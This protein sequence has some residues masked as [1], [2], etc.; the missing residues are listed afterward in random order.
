MKSTIII[1]LVCKFM[2]GAAQA[3]PVSPPG[4]PLD[5]VER[6]PLSHDY[7]LIFETSEYQRNIRLTGPDI[8]TVIKSKSIKTTAPYLGWLHL[9]QDEYFILYSGL[10]PQVQAEVYEKKSGK[11][12]LKGRLIEMD[13]IN[14]LLFFVHWE[15]DSKLGIFD[16][17]S[18][19]VKYHTPL[20]TSCNWWWECIL[21]KEVSANEVKLEFAQKDNQ[22]EQI[23]FSR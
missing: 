5:D 7:A 18:S 20:A 3:I 10:E 11:A 23:S 13:T 6:V 19:T 8:S 1:I 9:D 2:S 4:L 15:K 16:L 21:S 17:K 14:N 12:L 22:R